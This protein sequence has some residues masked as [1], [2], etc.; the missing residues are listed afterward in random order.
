MSKK[1]SYLGN[2]LL[3]SAGVKVPFTEDQ[4]IEYVKCADDPEYFIENYVKI[5]NVDKGLVQFK[6]YP[7]QKELIDS[8]EKHRFTIAKLPRQ[9]G[10]C[11]RINT[12]IR[13]R[14]KHTGEILV[15]TIGEFYATQK[16]SKD[17]NN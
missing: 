6:L 8:F 3:K 1:K 13:V 2:P 4:V 11:L 16:D 7:Y 17:N 9:A 12:P 10:K 14:N 15:T 5:I